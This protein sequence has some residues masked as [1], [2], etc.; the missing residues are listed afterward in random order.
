MT[1]KAAYW[2]PHCLFQP[3]TLVTQWYS[4]FSKQG[5]NPESRS[6]G[7]GIHLCFFLGL[8]SPQIGLKQEAVSPQQCRPGFELVHSPDM[9]ALLDLSWSFHTVLMHGCLRASSRFL[10]FPLHGADRHTH[11]VLIRQLLASSMSRQKR[12]R[13]LFLHFM[14]GLFYTIVA[15]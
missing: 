6:N 1:N 9:A 3:R 2:N 5:L 8:E 13:V 7:S 10:C 12:T 11:Y 4:R 15:A 14:P